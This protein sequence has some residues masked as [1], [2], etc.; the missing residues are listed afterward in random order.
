MNPKEQLIR[1][2]AAAAIA[3]VGVVHLA[4][5]KEQW[6]QKAYVGALFVAGG[7]AA[8]VVAIRLWTTSDR[9]A[10]SL[11]AVIAVGMFA[12]FILSRTSGLPGGFKEE[13]WELS[14]I[15]TLILEAGFIGAM[16]ACLSAARADRAGPNAVPFQRNPQ[17]GYDRPAQRSRG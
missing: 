1:R 3:A 10:W 17:A 8:V 11:G 7:A 2:F 9:F 5:A 6:D 14:G 4:L 15:I 12:G 13:E 16:V